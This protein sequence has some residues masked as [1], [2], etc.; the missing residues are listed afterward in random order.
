MSPGAANLP[1][2]AAALERGAPAPMGATADRHGVNFAVFSQHAQCI[3]LCV[4][5]GD[6]SRE[7]R[8][9]ELPARSGHVWHGYLPGARPGLVYGLRAHG[10]YRPQDGHRFNPHKLLLDPYAR[11]IVG[12]LRWCD[13]LL[14][15]LPGHPDADLSFS[16]SD[17]A[18]AMPKARVAAEPDAEPERAPGAGRP[19]I[20]PQDTVLYEVHV[21]GST[22]RHPDLAPGLRGT[23][24]GLASD[25]MIRHFRRLGI[26]TL[27]LLPVQQY[28]SERRLHDRGLSNYWGYNSLAYFCPHATYAS[29]A[30]DAGP[31][32]QFRAMVRALHAAGLEVLIDVVFNH[33]AE[34]DERG[35]TLGL[36][37]LDNRSYYRVDPASPARYQNF[38]GCG[39]T[40]N[41]SHPNVLQM[42]LDCLR[43]W[44]TAM[45]VDGFRFDLATA[46]G[47]GADG[48]DPA[49][50]FFQAIAQDPVLSRLKL[51]AEPWDCGADG[52]QLG[53]FPVGWL[54]W[55]DRFRDAVRGYW[56]T[57]DVGRDELA[58]RLTASAERFKAPGRAPWASVN[59]VTAHDGFTLAD[60]VQYEQ[61]H[62]E[63][64]GEANRDGSARNLSCNCGVEGP[65][66][67]PQVLEQRRRLA[68]ALL[69]TLMMAQGTPMLLAGDELGRSQLGNNNAYCQDNEISWLDWQAADS[70]LSDFVA[71]LIRARRELRA[72]DPQLWHAEAAEAGAAPALRWL[73]PDGATMDTGDWHERSSPAFGCLANGPQRRGGRL[74][75]LLNAGA[76]AVDFA[77]PSGPWR[78]RLDSSRDGGA[79]GRQEPV[80]GTH[81]LGPR[82]LA[83][84][85]A[86]E[87]GS[88][89][90]A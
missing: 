47:R 33:T 48:F 58:R 59:Y 10:P 82:T 18:P 17:S 1:T 36:R 39:N 11:Q 73:R 88:A 90:A 4:F 24:A 46:L 77:L 52:Y 32:S 86:A 42:V 15:Y 8:R 35:P 66:G 28:V 65:T 84:L 43:D 37:G 70:G 83:V 3:E 69:A 50:A 31:R 78:L 60:L 80:C 89:D 71:E 41:L 79:A 74:L 56:L 49:C 72:L 81:A 13:E 57:Q 45:E 27:Q 61:R 87:G 19:R 9:Y 76:A 29:P 68:R 5:D 85:Q 6:G 53:R 34:S 40:L 25:A 21:R 26:T 2:L 62:N 12:P 30:T 7:L 63:A 75:M 44:A 64:N 14:G 23:Y 51:I 22:M 38:S 16:A 55:N 54:E 20:A 67:D